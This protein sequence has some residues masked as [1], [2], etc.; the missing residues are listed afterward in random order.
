MEEWRSI[1]DYPKYEVSDHGQIRNITNGRILKL[2]TKS[3]GY[4]VVVLSNHYEEIN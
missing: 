2:G 3:N 4:S 1:K